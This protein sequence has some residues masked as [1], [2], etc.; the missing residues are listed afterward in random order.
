MAFTG[1]HNLPQYGL[2]LFRI[3]SGFKLL[4]GP[5]DGLLSTRHEAC[6][7]ADTLPKRATV[8]QALLV[9]RYGATQD[10]SQHQGHLMSRANCASFRQGVS[11]HYRT[12]FTAPPRT[13]FLRPSVRSLAP[14]VKTTLRNRQFAGSDLRPRHSPLCMPI[15]LWSSAS[16]SGYRTH[17]THDRHFGEAP[18]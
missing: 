10:L 9:L 2:R 13:S 7:E 11:V 15:D 1:L 12:R 17:F 6:N 4:L 5:G 3:Q 18:S 14:S 8:S 16:S